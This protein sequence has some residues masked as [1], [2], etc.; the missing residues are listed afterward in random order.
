MKNV[1]QTETFNQRWD[2]IRNSLDIGENMFTDADTYVTRGWAQKALSKLVQCAKERRT[3]K[4][5]ELSQEW[6]RP[7]GNSM[8]YVLGS[9]VTTLAE[10]EQADDW[11][12]G[13]IPHITSIVLNANGECS[14]PMCDL[15]TGD[16]TQQ[17]S[18][19]RL[20]AELECSFNY[21]KWDAVLDA[22][23][24]EKQDMLSGDIMTDNKTPKLRVSRAEASEK[25]H[26]QIEKGKELLNSGDI[27]WGLQQKARKWTDYN[28]T[29]LGTLFDESPLKSTHEIRMFSQRVGGSRE[30]NDHKNRI[31]DCINDLESIYGQLELYEELPNNTPQTTNN[32]TVN[33]E[34][35]KIFIGHG[36]SLVWRVLKDFIEGT[37]GLPYEEF[38][39]VPT[40][41]QFTGNRLKE[42][43]DESCMAFLIMTGEDEQADGSL[44]ARENVIHEAGLFQGR[45]GF[46]KA[47]ILLEEGCTD[48]SNIHGLIHIPFPKG[49]IEAAFEEIRRVL[50]R[51]SILE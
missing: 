4:N 50:Q 11:D 32:D 8:R 36:R 22:L 34:N 40:A 2:C 46:E 1:K 24:L 26:I 43:L 41:G 28:K 38:N 39:R 33:N 48:F 17:P 16:S 18:P 27:F 45:L 51:E 49:N 19:E 23:S 47:I 35:K 12:G 3:I 9:I 25:I 29:L 42:M 5:T 31:T 7:P 20:N 10:L 30:I 15:L 37:L 14:E 44:H 6:G 21:E 13:Q